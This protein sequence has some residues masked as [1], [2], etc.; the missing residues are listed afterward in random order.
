LVLDRTDT[1]RAELETGLAGNA[2]GS[3]I[4]NNDLVTRGRSSSDPSVLTIVD[5][6]IWD[7]K[8]RAGTGFWFFRRDLCR[9]QATYDALWHL[10]ETRF[11]VTDPGRTSCAILQVSGIT[12][13][14]IECARPYSGSVT[15]RVLEARAL[16]VSREVSADDVTTAQFFLLETLEEVE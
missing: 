3:W 13:Q 6:E 15:R 14:A 11:R 10:L 2:K 12:K 1:E 9:S 5:T 7:G 8:D 16:Q 4:D